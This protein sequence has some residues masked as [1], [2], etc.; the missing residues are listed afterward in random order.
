[1]L[2]QWGAVERKG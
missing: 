1:M 2:V